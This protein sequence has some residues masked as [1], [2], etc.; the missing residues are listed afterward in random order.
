M[1]IAD[2]AKAALSPQAGP[3]EEQ[4]SQLLNEIFRSPAA[5]LGGQPNFGGPG[6]GGAG[7][8]PG[9]VTTVPQKP[10]FEP[11]ATHAAVPAASTV[12]PNIGQAPLTTPGGPSVGGAGVSPGA[13]TTPAQKAEPDIIASGRQSEIVDPLDALVAFALS[14]SSYTGPNLGGIGAAPGA[15]PPAPAQ[16]HASDSAPFGTPDLQNLAPLGVAIPNEA[17]LQAL[18]SPAVADSIEC[19]AAIDV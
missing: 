14:G 16:P 12:A 5:G 19:G 7:V 6:V 13:V 8:T 11:Q 2:L 10:L 15:P 18:F 4:L 17:A 9:A 1:S 3:H